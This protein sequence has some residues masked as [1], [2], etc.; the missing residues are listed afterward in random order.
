M[1]SNLNCIALGNRF[2]KAHRSEDSASNRNKFLAQAWQLEQD[3]PALFCTCSRVADVEVGQA[4]FHNGIELVPIRSD[5]FDLASEV[6]PAPLG[7]REVWRD[8]EHVIRQ[9]KALFYCE[10]LGV[11]HGRLYL[12]VHF[13]F[14][15][16]DF[17]RPNTRVNVLPK[18]EGD[19]RNAKLVIQ[20]Q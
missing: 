7:Q 18:I 13:L 19:E 9:L 16:S 10:Q 5:D 6:A 2:D 12:H 20:L 1:P 17:D 3:P 15:T 11:L 4:E 8:D 14:E